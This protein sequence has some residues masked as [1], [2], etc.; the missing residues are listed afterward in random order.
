MAAS[1]FEGFEKRLELHFSGDDPMGLRRLDFSEIKQVLDEVQCSVVSAMGNLHLDAY[2]LSESSLFVYPHK[3]VIKTCGTT[4]LLKSVSALLRRSLTLGLSL[5]ACRYTRG[6]FIFPMAQPFPHTSFSDEVFY[7]D[8]ALPPHLAY[9]KASILSSTSS[10]SWHVYTASTGT[11]DEHFFGTV[12]V[13]VCMTELDRGRASGFYRVES[14]DSPGDVAGRK[15]TASTGIGGITPAAIV[16][17][18]A[19]DPCGYSMNGLDGGRYSIIHVTPEEGFSYASFE[20]MAPADVAGREE[21]AAEVVKK[22]ARVFRPA[23]M[24]VALTVGGA[25]DDP[26]EMAAGVAAALEVVAMEGGECL[27]EEFPGAETIA[28]QSFRLVDGH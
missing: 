2:V 22:V 10:H 27:V 24:T 25:G 16:C 6:S 13:E 1:G 8:S 7:L 19:F 12:T 18:Y 26:R 23:C 14:D 20:C 15:M 17:D 3:I 11:N 5:T 9:R 21:A 4:Q 28:F